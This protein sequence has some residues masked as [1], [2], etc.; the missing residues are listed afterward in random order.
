MNHYSVKFLMLMNAIYK[1][2][3]DLKFEN[4]I[5]EEGERKKQQS[6]GQSEKNPSGSEKGKCVSHTFQ[7]ENVF[8]FL[9]KKKNL[10]KR[11]LS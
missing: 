5:K 2:K 4:K 10:L 3:N 7:L 11:T 8:I 6:S 1:S 9:K